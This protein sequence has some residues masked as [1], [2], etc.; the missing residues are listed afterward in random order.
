[1]FVLLEEH[2][3]QDL[4]ALVA[5]LGDAGRAF[6]E[7]P[8]DRS[9]FGKG[10]P[11][12]EDERRHPA[13]RIQLREERTRLGPV[14]DIDRPAFVGHRELREQQPNLVTV[15]RDRAVVQEHPPMLE[16]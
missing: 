7:V 13:G 15:A 5:V 6:A 10:P 2:P 9:R 3:L 12:V 4:R 16:A 8:E 1:M 14:D 11:V